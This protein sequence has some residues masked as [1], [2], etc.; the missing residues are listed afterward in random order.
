MLCV[1]PASKAMACRECFQIFIVRV[2][3]IMPQLYR[4]AIGK[5][6]VLFIVRVYSCFVVKF[7]LV[8]AHKIGKAFE[9][10]IS[11]LFA[12]RCFP[13]LV[14]FQQIEAGE[15]GVNDRAA[16]MSSQ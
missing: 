15:K 4:E 1:Y 12:F 5:P 13:S 2:L 3:L 8:T 16:R 14:P 9:L 7:Q 11:F 10:M 6:T